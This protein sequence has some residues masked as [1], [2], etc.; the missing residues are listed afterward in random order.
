M[1]QNLVCYRTFNHSSPSSFDTYQKINGYS[2][3]KKVLEGKIKPADVIDAIKTSGLMGRGGAG[4]PTGLKMSFINRD[5]E[6][7]KYLVCNSTISYVCNIFYL[8][9]RRN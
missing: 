2:S 4:F 7:Q 8:S 1:K 6:G 5:K 3:W 9:S